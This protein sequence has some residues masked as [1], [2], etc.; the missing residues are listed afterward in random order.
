MVGA[1]LQRQG[2][3]GAQDYT[4]LIVS[5]L[6]T[7]AVEFAQHEVRVTVARDDTCIR[8][9][10]HDDGLGDPESASHPLLAEAGRG[11]GLVESLTTQ[12]GVE[13]DA[14]GKT[15]WGEV[16]CPPDAAPASEPVGDRPLNSSS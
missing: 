4:E 8:I 14:E 12:W 16:H 3:E 13:P 15:V 2:C 1:V 5:E 10:V 6:V 11:L 9:E 7:N